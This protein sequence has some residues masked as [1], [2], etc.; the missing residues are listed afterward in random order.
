MEKCIYCGC[1]NT[2][3]WQRKKGMIRCKNCHR[4]FTKLSNPNRGKTTEDGRYCI[5]CGELKSYDFFY[6]N[7]DNTY[8]SKCK[9]CYKNHESN[10]SY[11]YKSKGITKA[12]YEQQLALQNGCCKICEKEF[13]SKRHCFIDHDHKTGAYRGILCPKCNNLLGMS[14]DNID[15]LS[16]AIKYLTQPK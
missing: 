7:G 14:D 5:V 11:R 13:K 8:K 4:V 12:V 3:S 10:Y 15:I 16:K 9:S 6:K 2:Y 1:E